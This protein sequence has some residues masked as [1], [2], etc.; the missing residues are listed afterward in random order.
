MTVE[1]VLASGNE[2]KVRE[3]ARLFD[4]PRI[5]LATMK[6]FVPEGF[7]VE[8]TGTTFEANAW[9]KALEVCA[10]TG[11]PALADDSGIEVD[12]LDGR[13]G[14][15]S[16]RY[17][18][19]GATDQANNDLLLKELEGV[20]VEERTARFRCVLAF[21]APGPDGPRK[22]AQAGGVIEGRILAG[23]RGENGFGYDPLFEP[24]RWPGRTTAEISPTEKNE[25]SHR[26][27][28]ARGILP[29][30]TTWLDRPD[31]VSL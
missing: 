22:V 8:E 23:P 15:Y 29:S 9:L 10:E 18:G 14:V 19:V 11:K 21:A 25:I 17:A 12:A 31:Q 1:I 26:A 7:E 20:P 30:L 27:E 3:L 13:P 6:H 2:G 4:E 24:V 16:A 28:A 5:T